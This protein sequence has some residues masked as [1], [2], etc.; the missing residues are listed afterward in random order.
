MFVCMYVSVCVL[1]VYVPC[2][3]Q[4]V[5]YVCGCVLCVCM[6]VYL[7]CY[8]FVC[9]YVCVCVF[10]VYVWADEWGRACLRYGSCDLIGRRIRHRPKSWK[11]LNKLTQATEPTERTDPPCK[12]VESARC[13]ENE[14]RWQ[15]CVVLRLVPTAPSVKG[16]QKAWLTDG[17][18]F[19]GRQSPS[20]V[21][22]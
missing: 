4:C 20:S 17:G 10:C 11:F 7:C 9:M 5:Y 22:A 19:Q 12:H 14:I 18:A 21:S 13:K 8:V 1:C 2:F 6:C 3:V 15:A 16:R